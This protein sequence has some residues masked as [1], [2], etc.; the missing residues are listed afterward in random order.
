M[1]K[2]DVLPEGKRSEWVHRQKLLVQ[3]NAN[4][5]VSYQREAEV[6]TAPSNPAPMTAAITRSATRPTAAYVN[7]NAAFSIPAASM[8]GAVMSMDVGTD[9]VKIKVESGNDDGD[10]LFGNVRQAFARVSMS[11]SVGN[12][13]AP[14][15]VVLRFPGSFSGWQPPVRDPYRYDWLNGRYL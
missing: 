4:M 3:G 14:A 5:L 15:P 12:T 7:T 2:W 8:G 6:N 10:G 1:D 11:P 9:G 13:P